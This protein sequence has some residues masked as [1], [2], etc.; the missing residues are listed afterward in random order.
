M[1]QWEQ[2]A[3]QKETYFGD[4]SSPLAMNLLDLF[5]FLVLLLVKSVSLNDGVDDLEENG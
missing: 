3:L 5:F 1:E 2:R 4:C